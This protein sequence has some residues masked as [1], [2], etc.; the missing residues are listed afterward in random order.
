MVDITTYFRGVL[1]VA[2]CTNWSVLL[3]RRGSIQYPHILLLR[4]G[5]QVPFHL[6]ETEKKENGFQAASVENRPILMPRHSVRSR[7]VYT[8]KH[9]IRVRWVVFLSGFLSSHLDQCGRRQFRQLSCPGRFP[10]QFLA[11]YRYQRCAP[12]L[13]A[14]FPLS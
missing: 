6:L 14:S 13:G 3:R 12:A 9:F 5:V 4:G 10:A 8:N 1:P 2:G 7:G 11:A